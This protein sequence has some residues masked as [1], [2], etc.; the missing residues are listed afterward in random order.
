MAINCQN[1]SEFS[2]LSACDLVES[3]YGL[4]LGLLSWPKTRPLGSIECPKSNESTSARVFVM[5]IGGHVKD[6]H[7]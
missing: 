1:A 4:V 3:K 6:A 5:H 7:C 2:F